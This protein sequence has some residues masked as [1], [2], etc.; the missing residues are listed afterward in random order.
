[1]AI[2]TALVVCGG[3]PVRA[4]IDVPA[5]TFVIAAD[6]GAI[7]AGRLGFGIDL[8]VGDLDSVPADVLEAAKRVGTRVQQHPADKDATDLE[9]ALEAALA[10]GA[11]RILVAGGVEGRLDHLLGNALLLAS[12]RWAAV[13]V[14]AVFGSAAVHVIR[15]A[16]TLDVVAGETVSLFAAGGIARGV[17]TGRLRWALSNDDLPPGSTRGI[18][19]IAESTPITLEVREGTLLAVRP[20]DERP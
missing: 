20:G 8:L 1:M 16:R 5:D 4:E 14:D 6:A 12:P 2:T 7:E 18:S 17:T 19:N 9:L 13:Q 10:S 11:A 15:G 3:G